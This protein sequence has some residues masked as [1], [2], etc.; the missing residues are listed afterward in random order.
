MRAIGIVI[1]ALWAW[2]GST[3]AKATTI[4]FSAFSG[5]TATPLTQ[6]VQVFPGS[7]YR[8]TRT[9]G[10]VVFTNSV[11]FPTGNPPPGLGFGGS[12]LSGPPQT[13]AISVDSFG[14]TF[15]LT[16]FDLRT[17]GETNGFSVIG[18]LQGM[19]VLNFVST[20]QSTGFTHV[21]VPGTVVDTVNVS[22]T[23][24]IF[25]SVLDNIVVTAAAAPVPEPSSYALVLLGLL[26]LGLC[27]PATQ[28]STIAI[29]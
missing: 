26:G 1:L 15:A 9:Q 16:E 14:D 28:R 18:S 25:S 22:I 7:R 5:A 20:L 11:G 27:R 13:S 2:T 3:G 6:Y 12:G 24:G 4:T 29:R 23:T 8:V 19:E 10:V 21:L 17:G